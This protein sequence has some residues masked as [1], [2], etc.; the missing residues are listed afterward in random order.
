MGKYLTTS[1]SQQLNGNWKE[2]VENKIFGGNFKYSINV[3][4]LFNQNILEK[5]VGV[6]IIDVLSKID[7]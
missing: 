3:D 5:K 1:L 7:F 2:I 4:W 6:I